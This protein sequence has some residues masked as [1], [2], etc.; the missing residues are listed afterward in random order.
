MRMFGFGNSIPA[1]TAA[2]LRLLSGTAPPAVEPP[3]TDPPPTGPPQ[4]SP[5][6]AISGDGWQAAMRVP[7]DLA[8]APVMLSRAGFDAAGNAQ[9]TQER[10]YSTKLVRRPYPDQAQL[11]ADTVALSDF[12]YD[13]DTIAGTRNDSTLA[14]PKPVAN[15]ALADQRIVGNSLILEIVAF[16]RNA[17]AGL[18]VAAV[19]FRA[20]DGTNTVTRTVS[21]L[22]ISP[23]PGDR[24]PVPVYRAVLDISTLN[25][26]PVTANAA[27]YPHIGSSSAIL[28][29]ADQ[30]GARQFSPQK[31][32]RN[33]ASTSAPMMVYVANGGSDSAGYVGND[34]ALA[35]ASPVA[36]VKGAI[37][38]AHAVLGRGNIDGLR[39]RLTAGTWALTS[40]VATAS[41]TD[42]IAAV[43][44]E[45]APGVA[46]QDAIYSWGAANTYHRVRAIRFSGITLSRAGPFYLHSGGGRADIR[47]CIFE[48]N[49][50]RQIPTTSAGTGLTF[51]G[52][53][54]IR[55]AGGSLLKAAA[56]CE[57][58]LM[59]G[60]QCTSDTGSAELWNVLGCELHS[61]SSDNTIGRDPSGTIIACNSLMRCGG[62]SPVLSA[63]H[64]GTLDG[65][66]IVQNI[67]EYSSATGNPSVRLSGDSG[68]AGT[69]HVILWHNSFAGFD[70]FGRANLLYNETD[71]RLR[72]HTLHSFAGNIHVQ[73]NTK[74]DV[75]AGV[76]NLSVPSARIGGWSYTH[77]VGCR[78][79]FS[80]YADASGG[81]FAQAYPGI[82]ARI[83]TSNAGG[84]LDP[85]YIAP[86]HT[87]E[88]PVAGP[89]GGT[90][91]LGGTS[92]ARDMVDDTPFG[93]D[94]AGIARRGVCAAGAFG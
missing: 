87:R 30:S 52:D 41:A 90:Y 72:D 20:S 1:R 61:V 84:G 40:S 92:P 33:V 79:E 93:F 58:R 18:P 89:G 17:R 4:T 45:P 55:N 29:S 2:G 10:L 91:V 3:P 35:A 37:E 38:R 57:I 56:N 32:I 6:S 88:G 83:G 26:G 59:R 67:V 71:G 54:Q 8:L 80:R 75:F 46:R 27:V 77:G 85:R 11:T 94:L 49:G 12:V 73:I 19:I 9:F 63:D 7:A 25:P 47:N 5:V 24:N 39:I 36:S 74:H 50:N 86:A 44:I 53:T 82:G 21:Q 34:A 13:S 42:N 22:V 16:H 69:R 78:G 68:R 28:D 76:N 43:V 51:T 60:V 64:D 70:T 31:Y 23:E 62:T 81:S 14:S 65:Y 15:W 66:A 48:T